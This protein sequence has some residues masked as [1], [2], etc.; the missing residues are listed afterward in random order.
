MR[1]GI[2]YDLKV[3]LSGRPDL[4]DDRS[5][6]TENRVTDENRHHL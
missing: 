4:P 3:D 5:H 1:I 6:T 2:T